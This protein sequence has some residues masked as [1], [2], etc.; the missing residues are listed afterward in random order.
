MGY[1]LACSLGAAQTQWGIPRAVQ[2][3]S[4]TKQGRQ[5]RHAGTSLRT[6]ERMDSHLGGGLACF[7]SGSLPVLVGRP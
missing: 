3:K 2:G 5:R 4:F 1:F 6:P 7:T